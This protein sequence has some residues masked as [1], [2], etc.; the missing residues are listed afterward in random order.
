MG[1]VRNSKWVAS[2]L[3]R[4]RGASFYATFFKMARIA[5]PKL[6]WPFFGSEGLS[7]AEK[8]GLIDFVL[9]GI[10]P[11]E[12][13]NRIDF[14]D[15]IPRIAKNVF[16]FWVGKAERVIEACTILFDFAKPLFRIV[17]LVVVIQAI[18]DVGVPFWERG[19]KAPDLPFHAGG[20]VVPIPSHINEVI[21]DFEVALHPRRD[22]TREMIF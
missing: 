20:T 9:F 11:F 14:R 12:D 13:G 5:R 8:R 1:R 19:L 16:D 17:A 6:V 18:D 22:I 4:L 7:F 3:E 10:M 15:A 2:L 21:N